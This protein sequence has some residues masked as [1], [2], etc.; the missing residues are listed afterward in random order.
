M[1]ISQILAAALICKIV[2]ENAAG[3]HDQLR[4]ER[5]TLKCFFF[6]LDS[7]PGC[8]LTAKDLFVFG[9]LV[10][11]FGAFQ[12]KSFSQEKHCDGSTSVLV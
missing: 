2:L 7:G 8:C 3:D 5:R 6:T 9:S 10:F 4:I 11:R 12:K 1:E